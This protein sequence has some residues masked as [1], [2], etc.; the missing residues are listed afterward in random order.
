[1][2]NPTDERLKQI[3]EKEV[4]PFADGGV[5]SLM[6]SGFYAYR[7]DY[8]LSTEGDDHEPTEFEADL[9]EDF[10]NGLMSDE[11]FFGPVRKLL[12]DKAA[13]EA[14]RDEA[15]RE[16]A[17]NWDE[18]L[19]ERSA[20]MAA[21]NREYVAEAR[22]TALEARELVLVEALKWRPIETA[23]RDGTKVDLWLVPRSRMLIATEPYR[24]A[25]AWFSAGQWWVYENNDE[26][27][28]PVWDD[29][30]THWRPLPDPPALSAQD[31]ANG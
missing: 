16:A 29:Y 3:A 30:I 21:N 10:V 14:E 1:M 12:S 8:V 13:L 25:D 5:G 7:E 24:L 9:I 11:R 20:R 6:F 2:T 27:R 31:P 23:P 4:A 28:L 18:Y 19:A 26:Q 17:S 15:K 22:A